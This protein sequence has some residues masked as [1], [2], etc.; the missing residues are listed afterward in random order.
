MVER[1]NM[2]A[3]RLF[4]FVWWHLIIKCCVVANSNALEH[5]M[6]GGYNSFN[7]HI[8]LLILLFF[9][10]LTT[11]AQEI[12]VTRFFHADK[13]LTAQ[14]EKTAV[15]D[16][17]GDKCALIR[18]QTTMKGFVFD[19]GSAGIT[20]IEDDKTGEIWVWVPYGIKRISI[21]H[22]QLGSLSNY[23]FPIAIRKAKTYVMEI[24]SDKV[25][26]NNYDDTRKQKLHIKVV[27]KNA[28]LFFNGMKIALNKQGECTLEMAHGQF[29]YKVVAPGYY[30]KE[31]QIVIDEEHHS[32]VVDNL[33]PIMGKLSIHSNPYSAQV[34]VDGQIIRRSTLDPIELQVGKH[35][36]KVSANGYKT[37]TRTIEITENQTKD[38][39]ITLSQVALYRFVSDPK[40][41]TIFIDN[42]SIGVAPCTKQLTTGSYLIKATKT[43]YKDFKK[44]FSLNSSNPYVQVSL[45]KIYNYKNEFY[46]EGNVKVGTLMGLGT[47]MGGYIN[48]INIEASYIHGI[49][50]SEPIYWSGNDSPPITSNY[51]PVTNISAKLGYGFPISTRYRLTP[52]VGVV[53]TKL[54]ENVENN[55]KITLADGANSINGTVSLRFSVA[56]KNHLALTISPEYSVAIHKS[57]GYSVLSEVSSKVK[58][59]CEGFSVKLG[60][61][62]FF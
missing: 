24:T 48:N 27:A 62:T 49:G 22:Q 21:R 40:G 14:K 59:W 11:H 56:I 15:L 36:I 58:N 52:Q 54:K 34:S 55:S 50:K 5:T 39:S 38:I 17:N 20:K 35:E 8:Y 16:Q 9:L 47:T 12:S 51:K 30:P 33:E 43:G 46:A 61:T 28:E 45:K 25:F 4:V 10:S 7:K 1:A 53:L 42:Q 37:E 57:K 13:D 32:L 19:V 41:A 31:G 6:F 3:P 2:L 26:V 29:T 44:R 60:I 18:V 23:E